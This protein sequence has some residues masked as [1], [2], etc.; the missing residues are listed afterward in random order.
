MIN[1]FERVAA[2]YGVTIEQA[3]AIIEDDLL[4]GDDG[5]MQ[6]TGLLS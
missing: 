1:V 3:V 6:P 2:A 4:T 5:G